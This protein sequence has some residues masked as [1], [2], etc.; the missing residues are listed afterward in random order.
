MTAATGP[1]STANP[2][3]LMLREVWSTGDIE[4]IDELVADRHVHYDPLFD[5]P[6]AGASALKEWVG[7]VRT[8]SP[9]LTKSVRETYV[10]GNA[11]ILT[12]TSTGTHDGEIMGIAPTGRS[13]EL[14]GASVFRVDDGRLVETVDV[15]DTFGLFSQIGAFPEVV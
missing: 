4:L 11:V 1:K 12:Y 13:F 2:A 10:D 15:W 3:H 7:T 14:E 5:E 8:G 9:T 6:I